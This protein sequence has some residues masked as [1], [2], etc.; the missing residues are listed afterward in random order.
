[1]AQSAPKWCLDY[2]M[3][4]LYRYPKTEKEM[5]T[6]LMKKQYFLEEIDDAM[7]TLKSKK[8]IDDRQ[9]AELYLN[10]EVV[11]KGKPL[12]LMQQKL[13]FKWVDKQV[14]KEVVSELE[15]WIGDGTI[16]RIIKET[17]K[18]AAKELEPV[19]I[20]QKLLARWYRLDDIKKALKKRKEEAGEK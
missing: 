15:E 18:F 10:S 13:L 9:F 17:D 2:A 11:K 1:M 4:Y 8:Y 7:V 6:Q 19:V 12:G 5:R 14:L 16:T 3:H 20:I